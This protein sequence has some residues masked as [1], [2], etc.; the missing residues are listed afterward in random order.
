MASTEHT[1]TRTYKRQKGDCIFTQCTYQFPTH[2]VQL[3]LLFRMR[4]FTR[5]DSLTLCSCIKSFGV[6]VRMCGQ[7]SERESLLLAYNMANYSLTI[8]LFIYS[9]VHLIAET[10]IAHRT[11]AL[12]ITCFR[13]PYASI[14]LMATSIYLSIHKLYIFGWSLLVHC[15]FFALTARLSHLSP[16]CQATITCPSFS[17]GPEYDGTNECVLH[18][19]NAIPLK[20][21]RVPGFVSLDDMPSESSQF[22]SWLGNYLPSIN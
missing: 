20:W 1:H 17:V 21:H 3:L 18:N 6:S 19:D 12:V 5:A 11:R 9:P 13:W 4:Y 10:T 14:T 8:N 22:I 15:W 7:A 16:K 2:K